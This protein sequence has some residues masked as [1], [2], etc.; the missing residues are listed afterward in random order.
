MNLLLLSNGKI[1][2]N[3]YLMEFATP[4]VREILAQTKAKRLLF[5]P[6]A[7]IRASYDERTAMVRKSLESMDIEC[8][9]T[10][11]HTE[12]DPVE[13]VEQADAILVSGGNT[14]VLNKTLH[15]NG[16][17]S[18]I[19]KAVIMKNKPYI[20]WSAGTNIACPTI[21]TTNDM[22][23]TTSVVLPALNLVPFQINPHYIDAKIAGHNGESRDDRIEEF[24]IINPHEPVFAMPEGS[25]LQTKDNRL[26]YR[27]SNDRQ[28][29]MFTYKKEPQLFE[30][31]ADVTFLAEQNC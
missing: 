22:P 24:L 4:A 18:A 30:T 7:V 1:A 26:I 12:E 3:D 29:K 21:R 6:Y 14:W 19:R 11:I 17:I 20:G 15:D 25:W 27:A 9:V 10:G 8:E 23:I 2:G 31:N 5:I 28:A 16:L 13:A